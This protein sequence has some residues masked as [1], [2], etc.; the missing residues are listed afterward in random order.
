MNNGTRSTSAISPRKSSLKNSSASQIL[1]LSQEFS[2]STRSSPSNS[3]VGRVGPSSP[4]SAKQQQQVQY[5]C[6]SP[7]PIH[8]R[9]VCGTNTG[10]V[11][12]WDLRNPAGS[13]MEFQP[14]QSRVTDVL[15]HPRQQDI[16]LSSSADGTVKYFNSTNYS[17]AH[18]HKGGGGGGEEEN[19]D[20]VTLLS[21]PAAVN[22]LDFD[23]DSNMLLAVS[24]IGSVWRLQ[25]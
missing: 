20:F 22:A 2:H 3:P 17:A 18:I 11:I 12:V 10:S 1:S 7:H 4:F 15:I 6:V 8:E 16:V 24:A 25:L 19:E 21:E 13:S 23:A 14:H 5:A 9:V